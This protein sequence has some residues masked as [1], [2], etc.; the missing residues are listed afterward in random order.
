MFQRSSAPGVEPCI[1]A[2]T[3]G[4]IMERSPSKLTWCGM[5]LKEGPGGPPAHGWP[6]GSPASPRR[7]SNMAIGR[8]T[9]ERN[10][11]QPDPRR[12]AEMAR[13]LRRVI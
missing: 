1:G 7:P 9:D 8:P 3:A 6:C 10:K 4:V 2:R 5:W 11:H 12:A 13:A